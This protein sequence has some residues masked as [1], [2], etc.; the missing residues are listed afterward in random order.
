M[1]KP[2]PIDTV[3]RML[4]SPVPTNT[5]LVL[6]GSIAIAP[7]D[8]Q[9]LSNSDLKEAPALVVFQTPPPAV[10][11]YIVLPSSVPVKA[12]MRPLIVPGPRFL[13]SIVPNVAEVICA[14]IVE[15]ESSS[16]AEITYLIN[17][18]LYK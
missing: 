4:L 11:T 2:L 14:L 16:T 12:V 13:A 8:W 1:Y 7:M 17:D 18:E 5:V 6:V 10:P 9:Y 15:T 3:L